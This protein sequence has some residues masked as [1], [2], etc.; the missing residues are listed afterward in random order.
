[1]SFSRQWLYQK[2]L[3]K[4]AVI[5]VLKMQGGICNGK[6]KECNGEMKRCNEMIKWFLY[7]C[8]SYHWSIG[9]LSQYQIKITIGQSNKKLLLANRSSRI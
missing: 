2:S 8:H 9:V 6:I 7:S 5:D 3:Y 1:M 4:N